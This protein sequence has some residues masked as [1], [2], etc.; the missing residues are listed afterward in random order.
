MHLKALQKR[1]EEKWGMSDDDKDMV[2][3]LAAGLDVDKASEEI[4][5]E[6]ASEDVPFDFEELVLLGLMIG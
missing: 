6:M 4:D 2:A 1:L 5:K 3:M